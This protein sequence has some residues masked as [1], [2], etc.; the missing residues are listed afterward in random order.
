MGKPQTAVATAAPSADKSLLVRL[1]GRYHVDADKMGA[2]LKATAFRSKSGEISNEQ[3]MMLLVVADQYK[4]NP[5]TAELFAFPSSERGIVPIVSIDGWIRIINERPEL[6]SIAFEYADDD[7]EDQW[8]SCTITRKDRTEPLT[9]R[10]YGKECHRD[11]GPWRSHPRRMLR[12]KALIQCARIAFGFGGIYDP[13]EA[14]RIIE[15]TVVTSG[16][17]GTS[18][19]RA[20]AAPAADQAAAPQAAGGV[21]ADVIATLRQRLEQFGVPES[22]LLAQYEIGE[23]E[24]LHFDDINRAFDWIPT[25]AREQ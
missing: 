18:A 12:H 8:I 24:L 6:Q 10:E 1:A 16:K 15:S 20:I 14:D 19:P 11:T 7:C 5:F 23:L 4:L 13:D 22:A 9:V 3:L 21:G 2:T 25:A 17:S